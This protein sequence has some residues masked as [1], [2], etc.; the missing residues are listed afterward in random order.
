MTRPAPRAACS[1]KTSVI[2]SPP[3]DPERAGP[4]VGLPR[5]ARASERRLDRRDPLP[6]RRQHDV[7]DRAQTLRRAHRVTELLLNP[8]HELGRGEAVEAEVLRQPVGEPG[9]GPAGQ[10][11]HFVE[12][13]PPR[14]LGRFRRV[15]RHVADFRVRQL[16][17]AAAFPE[18]VGHIGVPRRAGVVERLEVT[19]DDHPRLIAREVVW[20]DELDQDVA[21]GHEE[22]AVQQEV[23]H[24]APCSGGRVRHPAVERQAEAAAPE[25]R[26]A[27]PAPRAPPARPSPG[28]PRRSRRES[29]R[30][31]AGAAAPPD[32][33][34]GLSPARTPSMVSASACRVASI[35]ESPDRSMFGSARTP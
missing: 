25:A 10:P 14:R 27:G 20:L 34:A 32:R 3:W 16:A 7:A 11:G 30:G 29:P 31:A 26:S 1:R 17:H 33:R 12:H 2:V 21:A 35:T 13:D 15:A 18:P 4:P 9:V 6:R 8:D 23:L 19:V 22:H 28:S 5:S 24:A